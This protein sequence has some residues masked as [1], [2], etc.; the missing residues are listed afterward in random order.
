MPQFEQQKKGY[1][2]VRVLSEHSTRA[3]LLM[4][5]HSAGRNLQALPND[6]YVVDQSTLKVLDDNQIPYEM[7]ESK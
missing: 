1:A 2:R 3:Y 5:R 7:I 4:V 6:I